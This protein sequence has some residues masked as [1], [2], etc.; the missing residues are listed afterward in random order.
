MN[1][2]KHT[3]WILC[4]IANADHLSDSK[5][6]HLHNNSPWAQSQR[7]SLTFHRAR[8][9]VWPKKH[10]TELNT[11]WCRICLF[12][13]NFHFNIFAFLCLVLQYE[14]AGGWFKKK[15]KQENNKNKLICYILIVS[16]NNKWDFEVLTRCPK[17]III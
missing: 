17:V 2:T 8:P 4:P 13:S 7:L 9:S 15:N 14:N 10:F 16:S 6:L 3:F 12:L 11:K 5:I 1:Y